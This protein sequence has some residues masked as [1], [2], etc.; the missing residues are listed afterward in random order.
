MNWTY[1]LVIISLVLNLIFIYALIRLNKYLNSKL[2]PL[3]EENIKLTENLK[4]TFRDVLIDNSFLLDD[5]KLKKTEL[6][7]EKNIIVNGIK[8]EESSISI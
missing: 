5:G 7:K 3:I 8:L 6:Q 4:Q 1:I 2:E